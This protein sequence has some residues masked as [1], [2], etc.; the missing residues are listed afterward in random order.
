VQDYETARHETAP[1]TGAIAMSRHRTLKTAA[2]AIR[3][4]NV[5]KR[6]ERLSLLSKEGRWDENKPVV[7]LP[8]TKVPGKVKSKG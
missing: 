4:R 7:G 5:L 6:D 3:S 2:F 1:M 8:K